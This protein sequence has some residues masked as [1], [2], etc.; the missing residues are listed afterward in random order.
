MRV[1]CRPEQQIARWLALNAA[2]RTTCRTAHGRWTLRYRMSI[3]VGICCHQSVRAKNLRAVFMS[4]GSL[5]SRPD[6]L[7]TLGQ[8]CGPKWCRQNACLFIFTPPGAAVR[9][10]DGAR[11]SF[12]IA[13]CLGRGF[14]T[15]WSMMKDLSSGEQKRPPVFRSGRR[16]DKRWQ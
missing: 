16:S 2:T 5:W 14:K 9:F 8:F 1:A 4:T 15:N 6:C 7:V 13:T 11:K 10:A 3:L 12:S